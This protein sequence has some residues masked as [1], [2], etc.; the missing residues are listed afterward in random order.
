MIITI[1]ITLT[2]VLLISTFN[3][4]T[5]NNWA[6]GNDIHTEIVTITICSVLLLLL[7]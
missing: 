4:Y 2:V 3:R 5:I 7:L 6:N 1:I